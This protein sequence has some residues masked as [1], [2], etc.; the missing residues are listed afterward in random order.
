MAYQLGSLKGH[1]CIYN[2][3]V[4]LG[5]DQDPDNPNEIGGIILVDRKTI[6]AQEDPRN[7]GIQFDELPLSLHFQKHG[8]HIVG[9][10][11]F[12]KEPCYVVESAWNGK[13]IKFWIAINGGFR[14]LKIQYEADWQGPGTPKAIP[15]TVIFEIQYPV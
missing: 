10:E 1:Q 6:I 12:K 15:S 2:G 3:K 13:P 5:I 8:V 14:C 9:S 11:V 4:E 7:W